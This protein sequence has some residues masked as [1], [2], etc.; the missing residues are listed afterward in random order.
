MRV[1]VLRSRMVLIASRG[2][3]AINTKTSASV[4]DVPAPAV[5]RQ[6]A[7]GL[8][9]HRAKNRHASLD[10]YLGDALASNLAKRPHGTLRKTTINKK[11]PPSGPTHNQ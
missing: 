3:A 2:R 6:G 8:P 1:K 7:R 9:P 11:E 5:A 4:S 10:S